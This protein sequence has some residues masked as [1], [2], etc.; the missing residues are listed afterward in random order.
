MIDMLKHFYGISITTNGYR[1]AHNGKEPEGVD[2]WVFREYCGICD[3]AI[4]QPMDFDKACKSIRSMAFRGDIP[5]G[6][7]LDVARAS[8]KDKERYPYILTLGEFCRLFAV[9]NTKIKIVCKEAE[10]AG[11]F[12]FEASD[13]VPGGKTKNRKVIWDALQFED[14]YIRTISAVDC[15]SL[16]ITLYDEE[17]KIAWQSKLK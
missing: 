1:A 10:R 11:P 14:R 7:V 8:E 16:R 15:N 4:I 5:K 13:F 17:K 2:Q 3:I 9:I 6:T 12:L